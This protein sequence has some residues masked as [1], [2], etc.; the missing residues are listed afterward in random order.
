MMVLNLLA[1]KRFE[2][3]GKPYTGLARSASF[4]F[5][6]TT[7]P[8]RIKV[9][10]KWILDQNW[11][12]QL[13]LNLIVPQGKG[14]MTPTNQDPYTQALEPAI[15]AGLL[16]VSAGGNSKALC[17][18]HP[19]SFFTI[20]GLNDK[21]S[22]DSSQYEPHPSVPYGLNGGGYFR[23]DLLAPY[24]YIPFPHFK[25]REE[26]NYFGGTCGSSTLIAGL[27]AYLMSTFPGLTANMIRNVLIETG[28]IFEGLP[29]PVVNGA[30]AI[31]A[32]ESG[33][34]NDTPP[35]VKPRVKVTDAD[36]SIL[37]GD[38]LE[39]A[40]ALTSFI[41]NKQLSRAEIW[42]YVDDESPLVK[43]VALRGLGDPI[44]FGER[45]KYW[46]RVYQESSEW[47]VREYWGY[48]LLHTASP[49]EIHKWIA[50]QA[51]S[52]IDIW[53]CINLF[54]QKFYPDAPKMEIT[55]DPIPH[56]MDEAIAPVLDWYER[57]RAD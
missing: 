52:T 6:P 29:A 2:Y 16:V 19:N 42:A 10:L 9:G 43:K 15:E 3:Q 12:P 17:N 1:H 24:T 35:S 22:H 11:K 21:G 28:D 48:I 7:K 8:D 49:D 18:L 51:N 44:N 50:L 56:I 34:R 45:E 41:Q 20:G 40:L 54:L 25:E 39:R 37:S 32:I 53:I 31:E 26:L 55:P 33:Y 46:E 13:V 57:S 14:L 47:G 38:P 23:P 36:K 4:I 30:K 5:L 27:C